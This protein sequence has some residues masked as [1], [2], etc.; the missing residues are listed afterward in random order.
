MDGGGGRRGVN[1]TYLPSPHWIFKMQF[2]CTGTS[3]KPDENAKWG[4]NG[5]VSLTIL[6]I[7]FENIIYLLFL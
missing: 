1:T 3:W 6:N 2:P 5:D 4:Q 7:S